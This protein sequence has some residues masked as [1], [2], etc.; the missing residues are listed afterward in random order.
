MKWTSSLRRWTMH[1]I[2]AAIL[3][4]ALLGSA[5][6]AAAQAP[7][8]A[9]NKTSNA[10][11]TRSQTFDLPVEMDPA[12]RAT[13]TEIRLYVKTPT[14]AWALQDKGSAELK[15]F[16]IHVAH[17]GEYW[18]SLV[19]VDR[20]GRTSPSDVNMEAPSQ[21]VIVDTAAPV[22]RV[23]AGTTPEG[24]FCLRCTVQDANPD[25][26]TLKAVCRTG[27]EDIPLEMVPNQPGAFRVKNGEL[28]QFP[29]IVSAMDL[30][31]NSTTKEVNVREMIGATLSPTVKG[32]TEV[33]QP[34]G[35]TELPKD[36]TPLPPP[37]FSDLPPVQPAHTEKPALAK[38]EGPSV[39]SQQNVSFPPAPTP[40]T[41]PLDGGTT[42]G[43]QEVVAKSPAPI[44]AP[45]AT[46][47]PHQLI[48]TTHATVE[49]RIDQ[50][51]PS[52]LGK[53]ELY[54]T[55]D[56]GQ[57]WHRL[58]E[59]VAKRS[60][61]SINLPGD[62]VYGVRI[63]VSN[64]NGFGGR[65]PVRGDAPH[66]T[67]EVDTTSPFVQ[68][69]STELLAA[70]GHVELR[71]NATDKNLGAEPVSLFY[72]MRQDGPW[73]V[74]ARGVKND[75]VHRWAFP[76]EAGGQFFFKIEVTDLAGNLAQDMSRQPIL[77]D[78]TEPRATV[79]NVTGSGA[80]RP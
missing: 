43:V 30:A 42:S 4:S 72:R 65:A 46:G 10:H 12:Y 54:M 58:S 20:Q 53:L 16:N 48:N 21:R 2:H 44:A 5:S 56:K 29:V 75:G 3:G 36:V 47:I 32:P 40:P 80:V 18:Y 64:G 41:P 49:Y 50:V 37:R 22:I 51:G 28:M 45:S 9:A 35:R 71:W 60:P 26:S 1:S 62:G 68:L 15:R 6:L 11:Y 67:I 69:R 34:V 76:R 59:D 70:S 17:D 57:S 66:C 24:E 55:P 74:I 78:T 23:Q 63:V 38:N 7:S 31:K 19:T 52:G 73:Q 39:G 61:A 27:K 8:T 79:I 77:I 13:L 33:L 25:Y 14:S